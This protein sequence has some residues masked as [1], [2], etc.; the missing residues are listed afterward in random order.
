MLCL[1]LGI[2]SGQQSPLWGSRPSCRAAPSDPAPRGGG[3]KDKSNGGQQETCLGGSEL[4]LEK[5]I[6]CLGRVQ[7]SLCHGHRTLPARNGEQQPWSRA[8]ISPPTLRNSTM[9]VH[10]VKI[11][12]NVGEL[13]HVPVAGMRA[14]AEDSM[15]ATCHW[16]LIPQ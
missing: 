9:C 12:A 3:Q 2:G 4:F 8:G 5:G 11:R 13:R 15:W 16:V 1:H 10:G 7:S 14:G 6:S